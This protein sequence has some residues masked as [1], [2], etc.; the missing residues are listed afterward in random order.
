MK[1]ALILAN[2]FNTSYEEFLDSKNAT[3]TKGNYGC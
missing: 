1:D 3:K 2:F